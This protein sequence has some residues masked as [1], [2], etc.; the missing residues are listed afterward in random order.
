[1]LRK[2]DVAV[3]VA[4]QRMPEMPGVEF[5]RQSQEIR[6]EAVRLILT[7][8]ADIEVLIDAV[9]SSRIYRYVTKPWDHQ[10]MRIT[11]KRA[12]ETYH[13]ERE[14]QR[15]LQEL[16]AANERLGAE[17][18][19]FRQREEQEAGIDGVVGVS[20]AMREVQRLLERVA[21]SPSTVLLLGET[22]TG[23]ELLARAIHRLSPRR[24]RMFVAV[25][26]AA[27]SESLLESELFA[28]GAGRSPVP[29]AT[30]RASSRSRT[31][32]RSSSTRSAKPRRPAG[33]AAARLQEGEILPVG[34]TRPR[35]IDA[36]VIAATNRKLE[37]EVEA[38]RFRRDLYY[39]CTSFRSGFRR[40]ASDAKTYPRW[41]S[42]SSPSTR[43]A[44]AS[45]S[46]DSP[47]K[48]GLCCRP[49]PTR[50]TCVSSR[51]RSSAPC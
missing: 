51:T 28:T 5:L 18:V 39:G 26:C 2:T 38:G 23:K 45:A 27:L 15:L 33:E 37:E 17:N 48:R 6:P 43:V 20:V 40:C 16:Q 35:A 21:P 22:G 11:L 36:R 4:D 46:T 42:T 50:A 34:E 8:Y 19:Y 32:G 12:F 49:T 3:A 47:T 13:L 7:G 44:T 9:N 41:R 29:W 1:V 14:N 24:D 30:R 31:R 25:N 10:E